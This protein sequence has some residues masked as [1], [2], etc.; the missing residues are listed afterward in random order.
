MK[1]L[2]EGKRY[3]L[4]DKLDETLFRNF[5][6]SKTVPSKLIYLE[7]NETH[8]GVSF[9]RQKANNGQKSNFNFWCFSKNVLHQHLKEYQ[10]HIQEEMD[11]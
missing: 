6:L 8:Y 2:I 5:G 11:I 9:E 3:I 7:E 1:K 10:E 4:K